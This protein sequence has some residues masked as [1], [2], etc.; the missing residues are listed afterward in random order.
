MKNRYVLFLLIS[1]IL[2]SYPEAAHAQALFDSGTNFLNALMNLLTNTWARIIAIIAVVGHGILWMT[3]RL[4]WGIAASVIGG[5]ILVFGAP[6]I[7]DSI[8]GSL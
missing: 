4:A 2:V 5:I 6:A 8:A 7:V 1:L 3:G